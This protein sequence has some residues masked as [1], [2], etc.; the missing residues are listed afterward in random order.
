MDVA[1]RYPRLWSLTLLVWLVSLVWLASPS[2]A[3]NYPAISV[4]DDPS[5]GAQDA[6]LI[7]IEFA[8][9]QCAWCISAA[10]LVLPRIY[11]EYIETGKLAFYF[12]DYPFAERFPAFKA[13][14]AAHCA[15]DQ[16]RFWEMHHQLFAHPD[17]LGYDDLLAHAEALEL[18]V[19]ALA[20]CL[21]KRTHANGIREDVRLAQQLGLKGTP[22]F[23][24]ARRHAKKEGK[25]QIIDII[26]GNVKYELLAEKIDEHLAAA[27]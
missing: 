18:D 21:R 4:E 27:P 24:F 14:E 9:H 26:G 5:V 19:D 15:G 16:D 20:Q 10:N 7:L 13:A 2:A 25:V 12:L 11:E 6:P 3:G 1:Q 22:G 17:A 8:H 23:V